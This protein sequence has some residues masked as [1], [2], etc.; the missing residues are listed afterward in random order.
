MADGV[1][2]R[3]DNSYSQHFPPK[4]DVA[5]TKSMGLRLRVCG[6]CRVE[7]VEDVEEREALCVW[8]T[9]RGGRSPSLSLSWH[10][11]YS[12]ILFCCSLSS[13]LYIFLYLVFFFP[14]QLTSPTNPPISA[15]FLLLQLIIFALSTYHYY[16][17]VTC[18]TRIF[19]AKITK[20]SQDLIGD[21]PLR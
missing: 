6:K 4:S 1:M 9:N 12:G 5:T 20:T 19:T 8:S 11:G 17:P 15:L 3:S 21:L 16:A 13:V 7:D 18:L 2:P 10:F 14:W